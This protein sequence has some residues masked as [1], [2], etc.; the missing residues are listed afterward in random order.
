MRRRGPHWTRMVEVSASEIE[1]WTMIPH[2]L[3]RLRPGLKRTL[4]AMETM[5][6]LTAEQ[7]G[8]TGDYIML[9]CDIGMPE[10]GS[11]AEIASALFPI[12]EPLPS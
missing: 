8:V 2:P 9:A 3:F 11:R 5:H 12:A 6:E 7:E 4:D 1:Q 10:R